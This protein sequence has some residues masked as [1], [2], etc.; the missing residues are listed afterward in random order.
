MIN[1]KNALFNVIFI[2]IGLIIIIASVS[3]YAISSNGDAYTLKYIAE[4]FIFFGLIILFSLLTAYIVIRMSSRSIISDLDKLIDTLKMGQYDIETQLRKR[5]ILGEKISYI[6]HFMI[7]LNNK[8]TLRISTLHNSINAIM[9]QISERILIADATGKINYMSSSLNE[10]N[11]NS[12]DTYKNINDIF[13]GTDILSLMKDAEKTNQPVLIK[14]K[15]GILKQRKITVY[16][17]HDAKRAISSFLIVI[18]G[19]SK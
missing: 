6:L 3:G 2:L 12:D 7:Q 15:S 8:K 10:P 14:E 9:E 13:T 18:S 19:N 17:V 11:K 4:K 1:I 16:P 5:G